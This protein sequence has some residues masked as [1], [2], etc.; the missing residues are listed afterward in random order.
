MSRPAGHQT[1]KRFGQ[2]FLEDANIIQRHYSD[3]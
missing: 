1:R 3:Y 2:N